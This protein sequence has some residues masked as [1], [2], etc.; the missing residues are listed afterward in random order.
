MMFKETFISIYLNYVMLVTCFFKIFRADEKKLIIFATFPENNEWILTQLC[1]Q[2]DKPKIILVCLNLIEHEFDHKAFL[3]KY[4]VH[5]I[6][7]FNPIIFFHL[8][9]SGKIIVDNYI[10]W[11]AKVKLNKKSE[12]IQVWHA[13]G[14]IKKF[15]LADQSI[16]HRGKKA[17]NRFLK[18]YNTFDK[19]VVG[20]D[21]MSTIFQ[22]A[23]GLRPHQILKLGIPRTDLFFDKKRIDKIKIDMAKKINS[24]NKKIILYTPT[25]RDEEIV[26]FKL[27]LELDKMYKHLSKDYYLIL[28]LHPSIKNTFDIEKKYRNFVKDLSDYKQLNH[29]LLITDIL[30]SDYSSVPFE[31]SLLNKPMIFFSYDLNEYMKNRGLWY[32]YEDLVPGP[33]VKNTDELIYCIKS[34]SFEVRK[35]KAFSDNWNKYNDG[36]SSARFVDYLIQS[37]N[38]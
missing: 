26:N 9:T 13:N 4:S 36:Q 6:N 19:V 29:L 21:E 24:Q 16:N 17:N 23:F 14:A 33:I 3:K 28:K 15:G 32:N 27:K 37:H 8:M 7:I 11:F 30:I 20:S 25:F 5:T 35:V 31:F 34:Q 18:V 2:N 12:C 10:G 22:M 1:Q 38:N